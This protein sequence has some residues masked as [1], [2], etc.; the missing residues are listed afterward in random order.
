M[1]CWEDLL[2]E[3]G[4]CGSAWWWVDGVGASARHSVVC[5]I[6]A[7][8]PDSLVVS[9]RGNLDMGSAPELRHQLLDL[10]SD[11]VKTLVLDV[12]ALAF[13]D[14]AGTA[15]LYAARKDAQDRGVLLRV[16][17]GSARTS[18]FAGLAD[19]MSESAGDWSDA[20]L[21]L[22]ASRS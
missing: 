21:R 9:V 22:R 3:R 20:A 19:T 14:N 12:A 10:L 8:E 17:L 13:M 2:T 18:R 15:F 6:T 1:R 7:P 11:P 16:L 5:S 4:R